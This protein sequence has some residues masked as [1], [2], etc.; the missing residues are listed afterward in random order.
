MKGKQLKVIKI[1]TAPTIDNIVSDGEALHKLPYPFWVNEDGAIAQQNLWRGDPWR[2]I[3]FQKDLACFQIDLWWREAFA[4]PERA[5][6]MYL[7]TA[8]KGTGHMAISTHSTAVQ[9]ME[10]K[11]Q[12]G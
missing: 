3:G 4:A 2:V 9:S 8:A 1:Q 11:E 10:V 6:G 7:V 12:E 5:V